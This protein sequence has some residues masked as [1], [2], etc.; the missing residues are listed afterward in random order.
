MSLLKVLDLSHHNC[1]P[2][3]D[4]DD[5]IDFAKVAAFG[6][7]GIIHKASQG[8]GVVD[9]KYAERR[10][11]ALDAGLLWGA[12]H[13][14]TGDDV[15]AQVAWFLKCAKPDV[16]TLLALDHEP[17]GGNE[18]D[19][20]GARAFLESGSGQDGG[21][22]LV[23]YSGNLIKEQMARGLSAADREFFA[24]HRLWL[25]EY[26]PRAILPPAWSSYWLWQFSGDGTA[27]HGIVVPGIFAGGKV[28]MNTFDGSDDELAA[29]WVS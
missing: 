2:S 21:R 16:S 17:N 28:D 11:D 22:E 12:Y 19:L 29:Q 15:D 20:A 26:G 27:T 25:C 4:P 1:G 5:P 13:F 6:V 14:A 8:T 7:K 24:G 9:H 18:L 10:Q 23:I 3:G